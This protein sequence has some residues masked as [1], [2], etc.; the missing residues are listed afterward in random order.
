VRVLRLRGRNLASLESFDIDLQ[1]PPLGDH[2]LFAITGATGSGKSTILDALCL[3]LY[4]RTPRTDERGGPVLSGQDQ[5]QGVRGTDSRLLLRRGTSDGFAEVEFLG[6]DLS[7]YRARWAV[8]R[9]RNKPEGRL[10]DVDHTLVRIDEKGALV[11]KLHTHRKRDTVGKVVEAVGLTYQQFTRSVLLPQGGFDAFL[12]ARS[13]ER[14]TLLERITGT[15]IYGALS[16]AAAQRRSEAQKAFD[17]AKQALDLLEVLAP[18]ARSALEAAEKENASALR[19]AKGALHEVHAQRRW[20]D[21]T[22]I[23][24]NAIGE[25]R[26]ALAESQVAHT[27]AE[28]RRQALDRG[29]AAERHRADYE[30][31]QRAMQGME[32]AETH[33]DARL[34]T[35]S[36]ANDALSAAMAARD[37]AGA[38]AEAASSEAERLAPQLEAAAEL[39]LT[40]SRRRLAA[41]AAD[42]AMADAARRLQ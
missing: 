6:H 34:E 33:Y 25:S 24:E 26:G 10:Q 7:R 14:A 9:A 42:Q 41:E 31:L 29:R 32:S 20:Y 11:E 36:Q 17:D 18:G 13:K 2:G 30:G 5:A 23:L 37:E 8:R 40:V 12:K 39:D 1:G 22:S 38:A 28:D 27:A 15:E 19:R 35:A 3:A 16:K 21:Q 4:N